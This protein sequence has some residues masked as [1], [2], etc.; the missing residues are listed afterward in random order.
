MRVFIPYTTH[1]VSYNVRWRRRDY[2]TDQLV[3]RGRPFRI[4]VLDQHGRGVPLVRVAA[5]NTWTYSDSQ[6]VVAWT[7]LLDT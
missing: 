4:D 6:G 7:E 3:P 5:G 1:T 2:G